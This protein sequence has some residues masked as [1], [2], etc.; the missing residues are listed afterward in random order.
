MLEHRR[1]HFRP[2]DRG[3]TDCDLKWRCVDVHE[4]MRLQ[5]SICFSFVVTSL[6]SA[7]WLQNC[8]NNWSSRTTEKMEK[9]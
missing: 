6:V 1:R 9:H 8:L 2:F 5:Y 4:Q 3:H 7:R